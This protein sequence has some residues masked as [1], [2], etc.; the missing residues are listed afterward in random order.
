MYKI[1][2]YVIKQGIKNGGI[3]W[4]NPI[5]QDNLELVYHIMREVI[6]PW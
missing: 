5:V 6:R 4:S 3:D 1:L 2:T